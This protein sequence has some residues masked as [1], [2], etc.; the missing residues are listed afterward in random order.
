MSAVKVH[1]ATLAAVATPEQIESMR[2]KAAIT[3][4]NLEGDYLNA[5]A[6]AK[7]SETEDAR[8]ESLRAKDRWKEMERLYVLLTRAARMISERGQS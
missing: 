2:W 5:K 8:I 7:R 1:P 4:D 3:A 6:V